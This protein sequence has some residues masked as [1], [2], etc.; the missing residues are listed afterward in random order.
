[1]AIGWIYDSSKL[2]ILYV[3]KTLNYAM[4]EN[5]MQIKMLQIIL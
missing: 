1:M 3:L 4:Q 2:R 5:K